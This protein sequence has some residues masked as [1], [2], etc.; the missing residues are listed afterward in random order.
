MPLALIRHRVGNY[1][2]WKRAVRAAAKFR[3]A[4]GEKCLKVF[5][6]TRAPNDLTILYAWSTS[7]KMK[8]SASSAELRKALKA[9]G[10][11]GRPKVQFFSA[12]EDLSVK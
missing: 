6:A 2:K 9:A 11:I 4:S 5:R 8:L 7:S 10:V 12:M 3:K 1:A